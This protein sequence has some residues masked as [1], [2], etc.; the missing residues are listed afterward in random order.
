MTKE[1]QALQLLDQLIQQA[2]VIDADANPH[3]PGESFQVYHLQ[4][5]KGLLLKIFRENEEK[6]WV[7]IPP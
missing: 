1:Q 2:R 4:L 7:L 3:A 6:E 5:L